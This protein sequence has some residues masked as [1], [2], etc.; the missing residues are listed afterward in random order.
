MYTNLNSRLRNFSS[1]C[2]LSLRPLPR[3]IGEIWKRRFHSENASNV[4][5]PHY[6]GGIKKTQQSPA[7]LDLRLRKT[8]WGKSHDYY[9]YIIFEKL[10]FQNVFRPHQKVKQAISN[11]PGFK[12]VLEKLRF[13][14]VVV[15]RRGRCYAAFPHVQSVIHV[16]RVLKSC[17]GCNSAQ[18]VV[19]TSGFF[20]TFSKLLFACIK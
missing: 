2:T 16:T 10:R 5:R 6:A 20:F 18:F 7:I 4:F 17:V 3:H 19:V 9:D 13:L 12:S 8:P 14:K 11:S 15:K 1:I